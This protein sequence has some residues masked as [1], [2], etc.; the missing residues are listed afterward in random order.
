LAAT[1]QGARN[2]DVGERLDLLGQHIEDAMEEVREVSHGLYPHL[3]FERGLITALEQAVTPVPIR[4]DE[5]GRHPAELESAVYYCCLEAVQNATKHG[6][7]GVTI[8]VSLHEESETLSFEVADDGQG[9]DPSASHEGMGLASME[10]RLAAVGGTLT[11]Q[12]TPGDGT[13][14]SGSVPLRQRS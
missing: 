1:A 8:R 13:V 5:V 7:P 10:D 14:I 6:G 9:F 12:S 2:A 4:H 11:M 3:L